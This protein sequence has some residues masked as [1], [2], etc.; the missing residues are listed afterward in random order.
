MRGW[1]LA[2]MLALAPW[3]AAAAEDEWVSVQQ[4]GVTECRHR[5]FDLRMTPAQRIPDYATDAFA[6][7]DLLS[8]QGDEGLEFHLRKTDRGIRLSSADVVWPEDGTTPDAAFIRVSVDGKAIRPDAE[9]AF[10]WHEWYP[11]DDGAWYRTL[12]A[13]RVLSVEYLDERRRPLAAREIDLTPI[14]RM[15]A[16]V[17][18]AR[19]TC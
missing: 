2:L 8:P 17:E 11:A 10:E 12:L 5:A 3:P 16:A 13:G 4:R 1:L 14:A 15:M 9:E 6:I 18:A 19:W 7:G